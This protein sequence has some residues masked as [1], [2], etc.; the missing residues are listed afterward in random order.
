MKTSKKVNGAFV[1]VTGL[2][3]KIWVEAVMAAAKQSEISDLVRFFDLKYLPTNASR[4]SRHENRKTEPESNFI[5][6]VEGIL[7]GTAEVYYSGPD[8]FPLWEILEGNME[9]CQQTVDKE[10]AQITGVTPDE[11]WSFHQR[12]MVIFSHRFPRDIDLQKLWDLISADRSRELHEDFNVLALTAKE[13]QSI[14]NIPKWLVG[15][16]QNWERLLG[17]NW[18]QKFSDEWVTANNQSIV[19]DSNVITLSAGQIVTTIALYVLS[20]K[21]NE[22]LPHCHYLVRGVLAKAVKEQVSFGTTLAEFLNT[23]E[24]S[25]K[26]LVPT[27]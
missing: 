14:D 17:R 21:K 8:G 20:L 15:S 23:E 12:V 11:S 7:P 27:E 22:L 6:Q 4:W 10:I 19:K 5:A 3:I 24:W 9:I 16:E 25:Y 2:K 1:G 26:N 18:E 13:V